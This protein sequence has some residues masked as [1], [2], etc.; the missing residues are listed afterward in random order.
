MSHG[1]HASGDAGVRPPL[2]AKSQRSNTSRNGTL[3][4]G[5]APGSSV[6]RACALYDA[7]IAIR[8]STERDRL[9]GCHGAACARCLP[10]GWQGSGSVLPG[11]VTRAMR[12]G[13]LVPL[14]IRSERIN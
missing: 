3:E 10:R 13:T 8:A 4:G 2:A 7:H 14:F 5:S 9:G 12:F 6:V 1:I 11:S